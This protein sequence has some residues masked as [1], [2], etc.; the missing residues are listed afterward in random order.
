MRV[1]L[2]ASLDPRVA[3]FFAEHEVSTASEMG[4]EA[5]KDHVLLPLVQDHFE[6]FVTSDQGLE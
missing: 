3:E 5:L 2:D 4:W 1:F 6:A